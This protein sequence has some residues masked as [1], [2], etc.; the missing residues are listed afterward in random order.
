MSDTIDLGEILP[1][2]KP[3]KVKVNDTWYDAKR[4][5]MGTLIDVLEVAQLGEDDALKATQNVRAF[6]TE[7]FGE[8]AEREIVYAL[9]PEEYQ[10]LVQVLIEKLTAGK[11][12]A[13]SR[14]SR[15]AGAR[16]KPISKATTAST[17]VKSSSAKNGSGALTSRA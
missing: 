10:I 6:M 5:S 16:S 1:E 7:I 12:P 8:E 11:S 9:D 13:P 15:R 4:P 17:S 14:A 3:T 2:R